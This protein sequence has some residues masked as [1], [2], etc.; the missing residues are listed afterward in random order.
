M[1]VGGKIRKGDYIS[2]TE[3]QDAITLNDDMVFLFR[4]S[5]VTELGKE[6]DYIIRRRM[7]NDSCIITGA[8]IRTYTTTP[9]TAPSN[10][11]MIRNIQMLLSTR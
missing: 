10:A 6:G 8:I 4:N 5:D 11:K 9:L 1:V 2:C 3:L 7:K